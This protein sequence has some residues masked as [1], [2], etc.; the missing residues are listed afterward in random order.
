MF[1][2]REKKLQDEFQLSNSTI[3]LAFEKTGA[4]TNDEFFAVMASRDQLLPEMHQL[5]AQLETL[6]ADAELAE[7]PVKMAELKAEHDDLNQRLLA[8]SGGYV[9]EVR[10]IERDLGRLRELLAPPPPPVEEFRAVS[11]AV[12]TFDDPMPAV[13][14]LGCD[15]F[16]L[17]VPTL[18]N[19]LKDRSAQYLKALTDQ[20]YHG[21][22]LDADG[23]AS[24]LAPGRTVP[25]T[26][27]AGKDLDLA[28]LSVRLTLVE[29]YSAQAKL[30]V[31]IEDTFGTVI[32]VTKQNL[33]GR[34]LKH[35]GS[36]TQV[37]HV[38][39]LSQNVSA[40]D[41]IVQI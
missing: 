8:M 5:E 16:S 27:L 30:P 39:G 34:M 24:L 36:L 25:A 28:Y 37:L 4:A 11:T 9:R 40:A 29:K 35:I 23:K 6:K 17:D 33:V 3:Q 32:D 20:R 26:E 41:D 10:D 15:L 38:T 18:W 21:I 1:G 14:L 22:E 2:V 13:M 7:L 12:E 31:V 19:V